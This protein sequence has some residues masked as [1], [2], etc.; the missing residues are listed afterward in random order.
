MAGFGGI[1][2]NRVEEEQQEG[3]VLVLVDKIED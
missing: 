3:G 2:S 1:G